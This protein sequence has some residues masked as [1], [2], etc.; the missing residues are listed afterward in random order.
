MSPQFIDEGY[1][2]IK[3]EFGPRSGFKASA[4]SC[5]TVLYLTG[6]QARSGVRD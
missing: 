4:V 6:D 1:M 3:P 2:I 5:N